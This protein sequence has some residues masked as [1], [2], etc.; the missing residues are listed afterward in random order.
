V[1]FSG[2]D[3]SHWHENAACFSVDRVGG[4]W[5]EGITFRHYDIPIHSGDRG[6]TRGLTVSR[7]TFEQHG[8]AG[9]LVRSPACRDILIADCIFRGTQGTW[10]RKEAKPFPYKGVWV[11]G[12]GVDICYNRAQN[13]KDG[14]S[15]FQPGSVPTRDFDRKMV[16]IDFHHND[17]GQSWDD[18]EADGGQHNIRFFL[19]RFTD[20]HVGLSAQP[21][22]GGPCYFVRNVLYNVTRGVPF[23]LNCQPAGVLIFHNTCFGQAKFSSGWYNSLI[24]NNLFVDAEPVDLTLGPFDPDRSQLDYNGYTPGG[25]VLLLMP[26]DELRFKQCRDVD[27][28]ED[29]AEELG[30]ERHCIPVSLG[31]FVN[32]GPPP[33]ES[34]T[35]QDLC[36]GDPRL[37]QHSKAIDAAK[38]L[39]NINDDFTGRAPDVG[40]YEYGRP[41]PH[42][43][44][45]GEVCLSRQSREVR[46]D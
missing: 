38:V 31:D 2:S 40:A 43:G 37:K 32:V 24:L 18:N 30:Y 3:E 33:G 16:A 11:A 4:L 26:R 29:L 35:H 27:C 25:E 21:V 6:T 1:P 23:K 10:R 22:Y 5:I 39:P 7:C 42:Y 46:C 14:I 36:F 28:P 15:V 45:R 20:Q 13:H 19:N 9:V 12:Q 8:A 34:K 41:L 44:P 17:V